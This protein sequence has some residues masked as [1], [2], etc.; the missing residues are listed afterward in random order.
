MTN[1][2]IAVLG[3]LAL[4]V[5]LVHACRSADSD[6]SR[7]R[8]SQSRTQAEQTLAR[9]LDAQVVD[10]YERDTV[11]ALSL[12]VC[13]PVGA[14]EPR[15][16]LARANILASELRDDTAVVSAEI[17]T[18]ASERRDSTPDGRMVQLATLRDTA[19]WKLVATGSSGT[20]RVCGI[21]N[22]GLDFAPM[23][24]T[25]QIHWRVSGDSL[26]RARAVLDSVRASA[27]IR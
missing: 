11:N 21:S 16:W 19:T 17:I 15:F 6:T 22:G 9:F 18:V 7:E 4:P 24:D 3:V 2:R 8:A 27:P 12:E 5:L 10:H 1:R 23:G 20:W 25:T 13:E 14:V 26:R